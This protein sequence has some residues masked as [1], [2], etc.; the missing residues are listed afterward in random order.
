MFRAVYLL[1]IR[2]SNLYMQHQVAVTASMD[3]LGLVQSQLIHASGNSD[4]M[5]HVQI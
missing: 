5:L 2:S 4:L 1:I 3:G